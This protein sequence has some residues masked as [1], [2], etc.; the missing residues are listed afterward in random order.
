MGR[1]WRTNV[2]AVII[3]RGTFGSRRRLSFFVFLAMTCDSRALMMI[4][5]WK[6]LQMEY[7]EDG[8]KFGAV[9]AAIP[10]PIVTIVYCVLFSYVD[11]EDRENEGDLIMAAQLETLE[12]MAFSV[13]HGTGV[14]QLKEKW[15][16]YNEPT[17]LR[18]LVSLFVFPTAKYVVVAIAT[19]NQITILSKED[20]Y[21]Q[22]YAIFTCYDFGT[23]SVG[24]WFE[25]NEILGVAD[26]YDILYFIK[27][28]GEV[29]AE[30]TKRH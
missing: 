5:D 21:Q 15:T 10:L 13:K 3:N 14:T 26:D 19:G 24:A 17:R 22:S 25:D 11:D 6:S 7:E 18:K 28:N 27:F 12:A 29:V 8:G 9:A 4:G 30:I 16:E 20:E 1:H 2:A 23:F